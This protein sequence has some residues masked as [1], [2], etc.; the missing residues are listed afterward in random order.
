[1]DRLLYVDT[2]AMELEEKVVSINR[3]AKTVKGGRNVRFS[4]LVVVGDRDGHVGVGTGKAN[5]VPQAIKKGVQDAKKHVIKVSLLENTI[6]HEAVGIYG[7]GRVILK[8]APEG[9]GVIAGGAVRAVCEMAGIK[10]I[11]TKNLGTTNARNTVNAT[12]E[13]LLSLRRAEDVAKLRDK[14]IE[15]IMG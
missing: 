11:T 9:T 1:M 3:V 15:E 8:P 4:A 14:S 2:G 5:E 6:P 12:M 13:A 7:A 10:D